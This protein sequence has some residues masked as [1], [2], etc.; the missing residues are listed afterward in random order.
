MKH[1]L[2]STLACLFVA[3]VLPV[4]AQLSQQPNDEGV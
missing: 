2:L 1:K 3:G 4:Q